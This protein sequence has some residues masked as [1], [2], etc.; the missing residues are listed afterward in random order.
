MKAV[1][2]RSFGDVKVLEEMDLPLPTP[3][4]HEVRIRLHAVGF[5]PVDC[6][7][8]SGAIP[9][10]EL[11]RILGCDCSGVIDAVGDPL[12]EFR[13]GDEVMAFSFSNGTYAEAVVLPSDLVVKKPKTLSFEQAAAI[14]LVG[15]TAFQ[16]LIASRALQEGKPLFIAGGT[17]GVGSIAISMA[18]VYGAGP[19]F[20]TAGDEKGA[21]HLMERYGIPKKHILLY[22]GLSLEE[23]TERL[24]AMNSHKGFAT[25]FDCV[26]KEMKKLCV[27]VAGY[28]GHL[29]T[30]V[31][32]GP[33][34]PIELWER[35]KSVGFAKNL[36]IHF[37]YTGWAPTTAIYKGQLKALLTLIERGLK[38]PEVEV[39]GP[40][41]VET[42]RAA[43]RRIEEGSAHNKLVIS[44]SKGV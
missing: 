25:C 34:F 42:V 14:P 17:G 4:R 9:D 3:G 19:I 13:V 16:A 27:A 18:Q 12:G 15:L 36:S 26:G 32:E 31:P 33:N 43:H 6:K 44:F 7:I 29:V 5:N 41:R 10:I 40:F 2:I 20:T 8:R 11:P 28:E 35:G 39:V 30:I 23:M 1:G 22:K 37:V 21:A 38:I 24:F